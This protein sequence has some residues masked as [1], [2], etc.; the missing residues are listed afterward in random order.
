MACLLLVAVSATGCDTSSNEAATTTRPSATTP[1]VRTATTPARI[2]RSKQE[3][4][5]RLLRLLLRDLDRDLGILNALRSPQGQ[6]YVYGAN[7]EALRTLNTALED[8][9]E[10][11][12]KLHRAGRP[13]PLGQ[14]ALGRAHRDL[15][16]ACRSYEQLAEVLLEAVSLIASEK[17]A[18]QQKGRE[19]FLRA[20][21]PSR[22]AAT[23][24][25]R[26]L[27]TLANHGVLDLAP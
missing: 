13:P 17:P 14:P 10:C 19:V 26:A 2:A 6:L 5:S 12:S 4:R 20:G 11:S 1:T 15:A 21:P 23:Y 18:E 22:R 25:G 27:E 7:E 24:Y 3:W 16:R 8:L 9:A